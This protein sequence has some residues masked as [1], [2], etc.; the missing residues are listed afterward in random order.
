V[1][2]AVGELLGDGDARRLQLEAFREIE[3]LLGDTSASRRTCDIALELLRAK[4]ARTH[5]GALA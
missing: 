2:Q 4:R 3:S 1:A 5:A